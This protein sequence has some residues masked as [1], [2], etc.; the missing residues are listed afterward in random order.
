MIRISSTPSK[1]NT[2]IRL[3]LDVCQTYH[4][5]KNLDEH[6]VCSLLENLCFSMISECPSC[7]APFSAFRRNGSYRRHLVCYH[8]G[9]VCDRL[10]TV[11]S[12]LCS[13]CSSS[14]ALLVSVIIPYSSYSLSFL[15]SLLYARLTRKFPS[16]L[17]L[18][19]HFD[20]SEST[21]YRIRKRF[22]LDSKE[23]MAALHA[24]SQDTGSAEAFFSTRPSSLHAPLSIFF[25]STGHSFLQP[26]IRL[27]PKIHIRSIPPGYCQI[28]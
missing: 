1:Y 28:P 10:I 25:L 12:A 21:Y 14:H 9:R 27:R 26:C 11:R 6:S 8:G 3:F 7:H 13:S 15:I 18:C 17:S 4:K 22:V 23:F 19:S 2:M 5:I 16:V 24:F 20:I